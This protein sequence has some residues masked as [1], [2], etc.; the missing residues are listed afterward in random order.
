MS[1]VGAKR[2]VGVLM[3]LLTLPAAAETRQPTFRAETELV[4]LNVTVVGP[5]AQPVEGLTAAQ[6]EVFEDGVPQDVQFFAAGE[7]PLDVVLLLD[8]SSSMGH[9]LGLVQAAAVQFAEAL[10][11][12]D[13]A[14]VMGISGGLRILQPFTTDKTLVTDAIRQTRP[15]GK[16]P[17]YASIY[18]ALR[19]LDRA[20]ESSAVPR[21]Q[22]MVVLSDGQDTGGGLGF[23]EVLDSARRQAVP[24]YTI[25]PRPSQT[26]Q[27]HREVLFGQ[28]TR[29]Q[30][31]DLRRLASETGGRAYFP[32]MLQQLAGVYEDIANELAHQY[33]LG[34]ESSNATVVGGF[35]RIGL[36]VAAP[37][38]TWRTRAGYIAA[39]DAATA[40]PDLR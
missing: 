6:F 25:A 26:I 20:R 36:R 21:R 37:G 10:R 11:A 9:S 13:R 31:F 34:Y 39:G 12:D 19:E 18:T 40:G 32:V 33:S 3:F 22:A 23:D 38:V 27:A 24:I 15:S 8:T 16:T 35:R 2:L 17:L 29:E 5:D 1:R 30:D 4:N 14:S 28:T 7:L